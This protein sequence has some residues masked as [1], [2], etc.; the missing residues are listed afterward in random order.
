MAAASPARQMARHVRSRQPP[1]PGLSVGKSAGA[2]AQLCPAG[3]VPRVARG[4]HWQGDAGAPLAGMGA[5]R[6]A[7]K[8][9]A[10]QLR[11][12]PASC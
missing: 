8:T 7:G 2:E 12:V 10:V 6:G 4:A 9:A 3:A 1:Q 11:A 5:A